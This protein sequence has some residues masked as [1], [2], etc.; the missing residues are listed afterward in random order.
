MS[1]L[2]R[3]AQFAGSWYPAVVTAVIASVLTAWSLY[4]LSAATVIRALPSVFSR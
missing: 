4:A 1:S 3:E 2:V